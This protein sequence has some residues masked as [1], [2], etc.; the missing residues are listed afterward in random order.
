MSEETLREALKPF[1]EAADW[2]GEDYSD[3]TSVS[4]MEFCPITFRD[5]R[6]ARRA[7]TTPPTPDLQRIGK[8]AVR[9]IAYRVAVVRQGRKDT[10]SC[11]APSE[12]AVGRALDDVK[13]VLAALSATPAQEVDETERLRGIPREEL[14]A[15]YQSYVRTLEIGRD[16]ILALGGKCDPVDRMEE[17][18][19]ALIRARA[20]LADRPQDKGE[21]SRG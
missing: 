16:R 7:L 6:R 3:D 2:A 1:A 11:E 9:D 14:Q 4:Q 20:A 18:D 19:P 5:I 10:P 8:D 12:Y 15:L 17:A 21:A 13:D